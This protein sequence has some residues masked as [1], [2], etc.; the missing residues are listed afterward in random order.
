MEI[1]RNLSAKLHLTIHSYHAL[2]SPQSLKKIQKT[3]F[4]LIQE[5]NLVQEKILFFIQ[6]CTM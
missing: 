6:L 5:I 4:S 2:T 3:K 1:I